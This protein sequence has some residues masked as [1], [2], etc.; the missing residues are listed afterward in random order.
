MSRQ[1]KSSGLTILIADEQ[2]I[3][4]R[5][6]KSLLTEFWPNFRVLEAKSAEELFTQIK[7][8][9]TAII[10]EANIMDGEGLMLI[11]KIID[12]Q[13]EAKVLLFSTL[14]EEIYAV[15]YLKNGAFGY[16]SKNASEGEIIAALTTVLTGNK[17][18]SKKI[19]E[20]FFNQNFNNI[21]KIALPKLST[22]ELEV[23]EMLVTGKGVLDISKKLNLQMGTVSTYKLRV[24][25]KLKVKNIIELADTIAMYR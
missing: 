15:P 9:P 11:K 19:K 21:G 16:M 4:L 24:F 8:K 3:V 10:S 20:R 18:S 12:I 13:P 14:K 7:K 22:R 1:I 2:E 5:G 17:Y 6:L 25:Q 23:A